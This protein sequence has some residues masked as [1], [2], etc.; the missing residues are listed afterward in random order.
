MRGW[1]N[2]LNVTLAKVDAFLVENVE[3]GHDRTR[4]ETG[5]LLALVRYAVAHGAVTVG[6]LEP[7]TAG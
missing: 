6:D 3:L 1:R 7:P 2:N 5:L 4:V